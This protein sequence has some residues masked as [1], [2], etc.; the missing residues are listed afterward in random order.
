[1]E[2]EVIS[3]PLE[4]GGVGAAIV[5]VLEDF[6]PDSTEV[7]VVKEPV[8]QVLFSYTES[9]LDAEVLGRVEVSDSSKKRPPC[10]VSTIRRSTQRRVL[11]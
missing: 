2:R 6:I 1:M 9:P 10:A 3:P 11:M 4:G 7:D 8:V 5:Q